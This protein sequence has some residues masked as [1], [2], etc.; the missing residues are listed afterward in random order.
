MV[1]REVGYELDSV[2]A[3]VVAGRMVIETQSIHLPHVDY[4]RTVELNWSGN[5]NNVMEH[6]YPFHSARNATTNF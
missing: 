4:S 6:A 2:M 1:K 3:V 5:N